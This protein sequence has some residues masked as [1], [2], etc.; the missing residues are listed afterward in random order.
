MKHEL[1]D[2]PSGTERTSHPRRLST[3]LE[4]LAAVAT[5]SV[6][7]EEVRLALGDR[8]LAALL[9]FFAAINLLPLPPGTTLF[10]GPPLMI[11]SAQMVLGQGKV[12]LPR[13]ILDRSIGASQFRSMTDRLMPRLLW[14]EKL[15]KPRLWPFSSNQAADRILGVIAFVLGTVVTLPIPFGNWMPAF[16]IFLISLA[17]SERDGVFLAAGLVAAVV[18]F[19]IIVLIFGTAHAVFGFLFT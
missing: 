10:L 7:M 1:I 11:I 4:E 15:V 2:P 9:A 5:T 8:S 18:A 12:W 19:A 16:A 3:V 17:I 13:R 14:L 6:T